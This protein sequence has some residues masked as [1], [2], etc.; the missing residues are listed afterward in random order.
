MKSFIDSSIIKK[1][2][3]LNNEHEK[4]NNNNSNSKFIIEEIYVISPRQLINI[5]YDKIELFRSINS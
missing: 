2:I 1:E 4:D 5:L 3:K